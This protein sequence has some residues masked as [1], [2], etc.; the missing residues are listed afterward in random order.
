MTDRT[1]NRKLLV[2]VFNPQEAREAVLGG[3]RIVDSEDPRSALGNIKPQQIMA[4]S[5]AVLDYQRDLDVQLSTNIGEDQL[6]FRRSETGQAIEKTPY[7]IAGKAAQAALGVAVS[8]GT[9]VHPCNIVKVGL[10]GMP[11]DLLTE[12]LRECVLTLR[13]TEHFPH[14]RVMSVLFVQDLDLWEERR[15]VPAIRRTLVGLR[16]YHPCEPGAADDVFDLADYAVGTLRGEDGRPLFTDPGQVGLESLL[17]KGALP[18]GTRSTTVALTELFPHG[19]YG[20]T[21]DPACR[22]TDRQVI[23]NMVDATARAGGNAIMLDTSILLKTARVGLVATEHSPQMADFNSLDIDA[24]TGL[25]RKG[26]LPLD[27]IRF[28][29]D[30]CHYRGLEA[31]LAGSVTSYQAQQLWRLVPETDQMSTR[32]HASAVSEDPSR[33]GD[34]GADSR[35]DRVIVRDLVR[36]LVPPEQGGYLWLPEEMKPAATEAAH[37]LVER[38]P[39]L[40]GH[41]ADKRGGLRPFD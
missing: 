11:L 37:A 30:Y 7:E 16:E 28:F 8:M 36:G 10:D 38:R 1:R 18:A 2:S 17:K 4:I 25:E 20:L 12:V 41:W 27:G 21:A 34:T 13:R 39:G 15:S 9:R 22:R 6:L 29:V 33:P 24:D 32:G 35:Q 5:D 26:V 31:N 19:R 3:A 14:A 23:A 40:V